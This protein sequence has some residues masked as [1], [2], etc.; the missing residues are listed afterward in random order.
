VKDVSFPECGVREIE[1]DCE[2]EIMRIK[3]LVEMKEKFPRTF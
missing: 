2:G 1:N 3:W